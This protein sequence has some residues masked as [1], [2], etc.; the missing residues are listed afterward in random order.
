MFFSK[1]TKKDAEPASASKP[2]KFDVKAV[3]ALFETIADSDDPELASM[4]GIGNL[5]ESIG[6]DPGSDVRALVLLWKLGASSKPGC[7]TKNEFIAGC[8]KLQVSSIDMFVKLLPS[9]DPG[10]LERSQFRG[11]TAIAYNILWSN[12]K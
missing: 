7:I 8:Q 9:L 3:E 6:V 1:K 11:I 10:F 2:D 4:E 5:C 12:D